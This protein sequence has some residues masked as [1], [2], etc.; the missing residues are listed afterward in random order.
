MLNEE[1]EI[2]GLIDPDADAEEQFKWD[3][4]FQSYILGMLV[5][6]RTFLVAA[7]GL[8]NPQYFTDK[9][10]QEICRIVFDHF[11]KYK[12]IP[13]RKFVSQEI[14]TRI[15]DK[16]DEIQVHY[17]TELELIYNNYTPGLEHRD[18]LLDKITNFAKMQA[19]KIAF[20]KCIAQIKKDAESDTS[21]M[22]I[23]DLLREALLVDR[24]FEI[25]LDYFQSFEERYEKLKEEEDLETFTSGF[26]AIDNALLA[27]GP[28]RGEMYS[29]VGLSGSGKSLCLVRA[30]I[31]N[32]VKGKR[33]VYVSLEMDEEKIAE[34]FDAQLANVN[35]NKL[36]ENKDLIKKALQEEIKGL[37]DPR[38]L[39]IKQFP[40]GM[41]DVNTL[42]AYVQQLKLRGFSPDM[43]IVDYIG[44]MKDYPNIPIHESRYK[45]VRDLRGFGTEENVGLL[46]A[47][48]PRRNAREAINS[49]DRFGS[50]LTDP[51]ID[52]DDLGDSFAQIRP[53][54]G[55]WSINQLA[56]E[57]KANIAR[58]FVIKH[59]HGKS[60]FTFHIAIDPETLA[61]TQIKEKVY[62]ERLKKIRHDAEV[63]AS[64]LPPAKSSNPDGKKGEQVDNV[65]GNKFKN[66]A[67]YQ[68]NPELEDNNE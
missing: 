4:Y 28:T 67:G 65:V 34:R 56:D 44:E 51:I 24:N 38:M 8:I 60:R 3:E 30:A 5:N 19:L 31:M 7:L 20:N 62:S 64:E 1:L 12:A 21:W 29:W 48:Q 9:V 55:C 45:I 10:H 2:E 25:G 18:Y 42:R 27:G 68:E 58:V 54:D 36:D 50:T 49:K 61:I 32:V 11:E 15:Q 66:D 53:L 23:N 52:D 35:I 16:D 43:I 59:R 14:K 40:A 63:M 33:V 47:M 26:Q 6:D 13:P 57:K 41:M 17:M 22:K 37:E 39:I 46:T